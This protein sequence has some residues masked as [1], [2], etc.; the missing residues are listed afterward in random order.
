MGRLLPYFLHREVDPADRYSLVCSGFRGLLNDDRLAQLSRTGFG[1]KHL[2]I[3]DR[4]PGMRRPLTRLCERKA[5]EV[6]HFRRTVGSETTRMD[7]RDPGRPV[8]GGSCFVI[9]AGEPQ[10]ARMS[11]VHIDRSVISP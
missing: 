8:C 2:N 3:A 9:E 4:E 7:L 1:G 5:A 10:D 11:R 6:G